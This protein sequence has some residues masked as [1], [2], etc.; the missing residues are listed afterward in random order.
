MPRIN[1][2]ERQ[3]Q[4]RVLALFRD[5]SG[6]DY[7]DYGNLSTQINTNIMTEKR[8]S[9]ESEAKDEVERVYNIVVKQEEY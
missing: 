9:T 6:L 4:D 1:E 2:A 3:T 8:Y 7:M 5:K